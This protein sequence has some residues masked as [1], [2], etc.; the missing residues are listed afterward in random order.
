[1]T[2]KET[3]F[4]RVLIVPAFLGVPYE[5]INIHMTRKE[6]SFLHVLI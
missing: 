4:P 1:M 2:R 3:S 5:W 6:A